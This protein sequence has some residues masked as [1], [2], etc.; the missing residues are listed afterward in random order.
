M[1]REVAHS[2]FNQDIIIN[3]QGGGRTTRGVYSGFIDAIAQ[4]QQYAV[5]EEDRN[6]PEDFLTIKGKLS[7]LD[8]GFRGGFVEGLIFAIVSAFIIPISADAGLRESISHYFP[9]FRSTLFLQILNCSPIIVMAAIC[10]YLSRYRI[11]NIT[12]KAVDSLLAGRLMS[13]MIKGVIIFVLFSVA[14]NYITESSAWTFSR[15]V[16]FNRYELSVSLYRILLNMKPYLINA[17]WEVLAIFT[18]ATIIPFLSVWCVAAYRK[19][20]QKQNDQFWSN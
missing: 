20:R 18:I 14:S 12:K 19:Y 10:C 9:A 3:D 5:M 16:S 11:G 8:I 13:L 2:P 1:P 7:F 6:I 17:A 15:W 4:I